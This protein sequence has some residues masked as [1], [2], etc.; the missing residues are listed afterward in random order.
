MNYVE[1]F[2]FNYKWYI[3]VITG[4]QWFSLINNNNCKKRFVG[5]ANCY[6]IVLPNSTLTCCINIKVLSS[7]VYN[8]L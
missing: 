6:V 5:L 3:F 2:Y 8:N 7:I 4:R 1:L